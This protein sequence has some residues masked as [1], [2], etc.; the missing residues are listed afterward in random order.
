MLSSADAYSTHDDELR[1]LSLSRTGRWLAKKVGVHEK[2]ITS[3][4]LYDFICEEDRERV[5]SVIQCIL[6]NADESDG[7][8]MDHLRL[9]CG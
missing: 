6:S 4:A 9:Y 2:A 5:R 1:F 8:D 3:Y 7:D